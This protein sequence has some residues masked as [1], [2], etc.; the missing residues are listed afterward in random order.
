MTHQKKVRKR[1]RDAMTAEGNKESV[2]MIT[3]MKAG[4]VHHMPS[5]GQGQGQ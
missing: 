2:L 4:S 5:Q 3:E 1:S